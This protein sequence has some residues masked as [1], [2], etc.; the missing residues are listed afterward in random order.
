MQG[1]GIPQLI[2]EGGMAFGTG[3]HA[4]TKLCCNWLQRVV[5]KGV[6]VL[7]YGAGSGI[8]GMASLRFGAESSVGVDIGMSPLRI[9]AVGSC[10]VV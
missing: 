10:R 7:D 9:K 2:L 4:T 1:D 3:E 6:R 8:L 5:A